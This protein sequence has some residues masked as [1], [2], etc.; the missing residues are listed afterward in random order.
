MDCWCVLVHCGLFSPFF[1]LTSSDREATR[2][3]IYGV[4]FSPSSTIILFYSHPQSLSISFIMTPI[5]SSFILNITGRFLLQSL[6]SFCFAVCF[7]WICYFFAPQPAFHL[8]FIISNSNTPCSSHFGNIT[9]KILKRSLLSCC[10]NLIISHLN[11]HSKPCHKVRFH[12]QVV[13]RV[14]TN[15]LMGHGRHSAGSTLYV[16]RHSQNF[17]FLP[18][19]LPCSLSALPCPALTCVALLWSLSLYFLR[20]CCWKSALNSNWNSCFVHSRNRCWKQ[21]GSIFTLR[22]RERERQRGLRSTKN[23]YY[24]CRGSGDGFQWHTRGGG[25]FAVHSSRYVVVGI[26]G[27]HGSDNSGVLGGAGFVEAE[28]EKRAPSF[29]SCGFPC[30]GSV[31]LSQVAWLDCLLFKRLSYPSGGLSWFHHHLHCPPW[32]CGAHTQE[33]FPQ[34]PKGTYVCTMYVLLY[35]I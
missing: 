2:I 4:S 11:D 3:V 7:L 34:L 33:Q 6:H 21:Q 8:T 9:K 1:F 16:E 15:P 27:V 5:A 23:G 26:G 25:N 30:R 35:R 18:A 17:H 29:A 19:L 14:L 31:E 24:P 13:P 22:E 10:R 12:H 20:F 32:K 28:G